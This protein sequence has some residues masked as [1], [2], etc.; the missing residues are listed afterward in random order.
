MLAPCLSPQTANVAAPAPPPPACSVTPTVMYPNLWYWTSVSKVS[1]TSMSPQS[2]GSNPHVSMACMSVLWTFL[3]L[4][5]TSTVKNPSS[6]EYSYNVPN[7][8][9]M[10]PSNLTSYVTINWVFSSKV[11]LIEEVYSKHLLNAYLLLPPSL[12]CTPVWAF[13]E[14]QP[15]SFDVPC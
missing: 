15:K 8:L 1:H 14:V 13:H 7:F 5:C 4:S 11:K 10:R 6:Q 3:W 12:L 2:H 9:H